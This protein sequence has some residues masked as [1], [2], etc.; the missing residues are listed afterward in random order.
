MLY[1]DF[2]PFGEALEDVETGVGA[3]QDVGRHKEQ[4]LFRVFHPRHSFAEPTGN[5]SLLSILRLAD[6]IEEEVGQVSDCLAAFFARREVA[7]NDIGDDVLVDDNLFLAGGKGDGVGALEI[8]IGDGRDEDEVTEV[9][10]L[11]EG[12]YGVLPQLAILESQTVAD[13]ELAVGQFVP[14]CVDKWSAR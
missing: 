3:W 2:E 14:G 5:G 11:E 9:L 12:P 7:G 6:V 13:D 10:H 4:T 8:E 1:P